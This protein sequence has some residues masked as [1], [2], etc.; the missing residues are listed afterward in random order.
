MTVM[1][2]LSWNQLEFV[3]SL[4]MEE[5]QHDDELPYNIIA[6][7]LFCIM[8]LHLFAIYFGMSFHFQSFDKLI[9][10]LQW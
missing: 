8:F 6:L 7:F 4:Q 2:I 9:N 5:L 1:V 10:Y 3:R